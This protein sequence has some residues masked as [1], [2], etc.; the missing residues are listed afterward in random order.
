MSRITR[1]DTRLDI[2][3]AE[4][5]IKTDTEL[6]EQLGIKPSALS[7]RLKNEVSIK[8][9]HAIANLFGITIKQLLK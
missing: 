5:G 9:L 3:M 4:H 1:D 2:L 6:G 8:T 7:H